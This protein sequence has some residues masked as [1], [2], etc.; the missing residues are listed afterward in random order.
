MTYQIIDKE[1]YIEVCADGTA[2][3]WD[4]LKVIHKMKQLD[5][6]KE[7]PDLWILAESL[8]FSLYSFSPLIQGI[9]C[10]LAR[11][12]VKKGCKSA[13]LAADEF[14]KAKIDIYCA[15]A[16]ALPFQLQAFT[17]RADALAWLL[18]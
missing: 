10:L 1:D 13:I 17:T 5:A 3:H 9:Q 4:L 15:E 2:C 16:S 12:A 11:F 18:N 8:N 6:K 14:Q 7:K